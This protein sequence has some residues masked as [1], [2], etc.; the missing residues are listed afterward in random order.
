MGE[1]VDFTV[2]PQLEEGLETE[3]ISYQEE[4]VNIDLQ[5]NFV[6]KINNEIKDTIHIENGHAILTKRIGKHIF[7]GTE[8]TWL[9]NN[10]YKNETMGFLCIIDGMKNTTYNNKEIDCNKFTFGITWNKDD[11]VI[12]NSSNKVIFRIKISRLDSADISGFK[13]WL[14]ENH[15]I[16][17]YPLAESYD[18]DLG[19]VKLPKTF[20]GISN[21]FLNANLETNMHVDYVKDTQLVIDD[22]Q[23]QI[24]N[25]TA[26]LSTTN[27]SALLLDNLQSDLEGEVI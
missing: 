13:K 1:T 3:Y 10:E 11:E 2:Y 5:D 22:L 25:I 21:I 12:N 14:S 26:L 20:K 8:D 23:S 4:T 16:L 27:T 9:Y 6:A 7:D 17:Y 18:V 24:D 15:P 19:P